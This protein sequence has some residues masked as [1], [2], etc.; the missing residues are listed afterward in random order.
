MGRYFYCLLHIILTVQFANGQSHGLAF[1]S[2]EVVPEKRTS[3]DL[4][5]TDPVCLGD[6]TEISFD[7][8][9]RPNLE[10]YFG[11]VMRLLTDDHRN[12]DLVY[13]QR[14]ATF[15]F[16]IRE[17][18]TGSFVI[19]TTQIF[20]KWSR[21]RL[22]FDGK[23]QEASFYYNNE[24]ITKGHIGLDK[25]PCARIFFGANSFEGFQ[26]LDVPPMRIKDIRIKADG[27]LIHYYPLS[28]S[29]GTTAQD[30]VTRQAARVKNP[31]WIKPRHQHWEQVAALQTKGA[32]STAFDKKQEVLYIV[33]VDSLYRLSLKNMTLTGEP[34]TRSRDILPA[35]NQSVYS[36]A[37]N[38]LYNFYI[39]EKQV[40]AYD[41]VSR[42]WDSAFSS[43]ELTEFW[44]ANKFLSPRDSAL[45]I[46][47]GYGQLQYKNLV[48][49]YH[50]PTRQW[51]L[52][53]VKGDTLM[54][55]YLA[56]LGVN[57][58]NDTA[59][60]MGGYGSNTGNQAVNPKYNYDLTAYSI[61]DSTFHLRYHQPEP[62]RQFCFANSLVIDPA[63]QD[64]YTLIYPNDQ[65]NSSLQLIRG[66]LFQPGYQLIGDTIPYAFYDVRSFAD[67]F[68]SPVSQK[69]VAVTLYHSKENIASV[70]VYTL[71]FPP[72]PAEPATAAAAGGRGYWMYLLAG[73]VLL[74]GI[75][76]LWRKKRRPA[77]TGTAPD[78]AAFPEEEMEKQPDTSAI[79]LFGQFEV[80]DKEGQDITKLFTP[81]LKELFLLLVLHSMKD[82]KGI[83]SE[84]LY[85]ILWNDKSP[86]DA[87]N[88]FS[89]NIVKLKAI[90]E[91]IG[92]F[93]IGRESGKWKLD[94]VE[95]HI[96]VD[97]QHFIRLLHDHP[98]G[99][100]H[101]FVHG[102][103]E[104]VHRGAL[105]RT[106]HY[107]WLDPLKFDTSV[108]VIDL[109]LKYAS[110]ADL[111]A[112]AEFIVR[113]ANA[114]FQF[115]NLN[116]EALAWK[117]KAL[118]HLGRHSMAKE[119]YGKFAKEYRE[120][121]GQDFGKSLVEI[122]QQA[123]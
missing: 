105:L 12:I 102:L 115:D 6:V 81:L 1:S 73:V 15:N 37:Q 46:M 7:L 8:M 56:A 42:S 19:D 107:E 63:G 47:C 88:N 24:L 114:I 17:V 84:E 112:E 49:R 103:L 33:T 39:D 11:Y 77:E 27:K 44:Q 64:Y 76:L 13:N 92:G 57:E 74:S 78:N 72:N 111:H 38:R 23:R 120:S 117:S 85:D 59:F 119:T 87:R 93:H 96:Y 100:D 99:I 110:R 116:E 58:T 91:K 2:H 16:V 36:S 20:G 30:E 113:I 28:E 60:I 54:P 51:T 25:R 26:T 31:V 61:G 90:L 5:P 41:P 4:T 86:K 10:T 80:F 122:T 82:G 101:A 98:H 32:P 48:Q 75:L 45:Y 50:F 121:Y 29:S 3:L 34:A 97:Y 95:E 71:D 89:V 94:V 83:A 21:F 55:R 118:I 14:L 70:K 66:S 123:G 68:Y 9:L 104:I 79:Y 53:P 40:S 62:P 67:L 35:G 52:V 69:L 18:I 109:L 65:F 108:Q 106:V 22:L 43:M